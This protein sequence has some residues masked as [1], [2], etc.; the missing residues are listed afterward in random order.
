MILDQKFYVFGREYI[1][2]SRESKERVRSEWEESGKRVGRYWEE[3]GT[4]RKN[5]KEI[6]ISSFLPIKSTPRFAMVTI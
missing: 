6:F 4:V 5:T 1:E 3:S 2:K